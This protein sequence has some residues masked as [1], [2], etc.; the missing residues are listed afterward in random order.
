MAKLSVETPDA[1]DKK[2]TSNYALRLQ[3]SL[4]DEAE[5]L[6][7]AEGTTLNQLI[8]VAVAEKLTRLRDETYF[9]ERAD[10]A[11]VGRALAMMQRPRGEPPRH[12]DA[13]QADGP[14]SVASERAED[15]IGRP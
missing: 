4:K 12:G 5:R 1:P 3:A 14:G 15:P 8:N 7:R 6:A 9:R 2:R 10:R 13:P 11:D